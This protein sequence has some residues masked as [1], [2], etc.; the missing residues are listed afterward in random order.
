MKKILLTTFLVITVI[1]LT[2][3]TSSAVFTAEIPDYVNYSG[4]AWFEVYDSYL[5][6][7]T[8]IF[9]LEF[10]DNIF[11]FKLSD[12]DLPSD[13]VNFSNSTVYGLVITSNGT[14]YSCRCSRF[15]TIEVQTTSSSYNTYV[16]LS[17]NVL[18]LSNSNML[19]ITEDTNYIN[20]TVPDY[21]KYY[22]AIFAFLAFCEFFGLCS[23]LLRRGRK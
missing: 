17:P 23:N 12:T 1:F 6:R 7:C 8:V 20:D 21:E 16:D 13:I 2:C 18:S 3:F 22:L 11:G 19:F 9:P 4:G 10:K 15:S 14:E 5:G